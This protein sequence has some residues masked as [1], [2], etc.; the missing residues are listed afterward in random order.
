MHDVTMPKL[1]DSMEI[2]KIVTWRV[3]EGDQVKEGDTIADVESDKA[4]MEL[5]AFHTGTLVKIVHGDGEEV[6]VGDVIAFVGD[7]SEKAPEVPVKSIA[8]VTPSV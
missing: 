4:V 2:G 1:S 8:S 5:E 7:A 6:P 3:A